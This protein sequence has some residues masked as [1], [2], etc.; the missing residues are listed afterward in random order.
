MVPSL[1]VLNARGA[2]MQGQMLTLSGVAPQT[3]VFADRPVRAAG[4]VMTKYLLEEWDAGGSFAKDAPNASVSVFSKAGDAM[5]D[6]VVELTNPRLASR[7][8]G[9]RLTVR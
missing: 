3:I 9:A 4:H 5:R 6:A 1:F 7:K 8:R 2:T